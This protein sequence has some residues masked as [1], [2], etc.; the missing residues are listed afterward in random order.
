[1]HMKNNLR[2]I[3]NMIGVSL[4]WCALFFA[5]LMSGTGCKRYKVT[6][7]SELVGNTHHQVDGR[8]DVVQSGSSATVIEYKINLDICTSLKD[9][10]LKSTDGDEVRANE[11]QAKCIEELV[12][13]LGEIK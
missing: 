12:E 2:T 8:V 4:I 9:A 13:L 10:V 11:A 3:L 1:M 6:T 5:I 7:K